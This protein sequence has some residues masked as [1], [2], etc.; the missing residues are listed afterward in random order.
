M[1]RTS[2]ATSPPRSAFVT[3]AVLFMLA[4]SSANALTFANVTGSG[5]LHVTATGTIYFDS[6][7]L[8]L[9]NL[10]IIAS[11]SV[12]FDT[13]FPTGVPDPPTATVDLLNQMG[14]SELS[15][16]GDVYFDRF[17]F[18][19][20]LSI[21]A[22]RVFAIGPFTISGNATLDTGSVTI[23]SPIPGAIINACGDRCNIHM[24]VTPD[25][26]PLFDPNSGPTLTAAV[27][28]PSGALLFALGV[29]SVAAYNRNRSPS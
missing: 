26:G 11:D 3:T 12:V 2:P 23:G 18:S 25:G 22:D 19:G 8:D 1:R 4:S 14:M 29:I 13:T 5:D 27:P 9:N 16:T 7:N 28:E 6:S 21:V 24:V 17:E 20:D 10:S 15:V